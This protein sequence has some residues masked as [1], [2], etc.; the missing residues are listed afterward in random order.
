MLTWAIFVNTQLKKGFTAAQVAEKQAWPE[1]LV[2]SVALEGKDDL[3]RFRSLKQRGQVF[4]L[5]RF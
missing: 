5:D 2:W 1:P 4:I 3:E